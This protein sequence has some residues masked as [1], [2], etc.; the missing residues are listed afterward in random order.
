MRPAESVAR[1]NALAV[2]RFFKDVTAGDRWLHGVFADLEFE[3]REVIAADDRVVVRGVMRGR[4]VGPLLGV[5]PPGR[6]VEIP[7]VHIFR[8]ADARIVE[9][10]E[11]WSELSVLMQ[12]EFDLIRA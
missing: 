12:L 6:S 3:E 5:A 4:H 9:H 7:Q 1:A 10:Y 11:L 8:L 2:R